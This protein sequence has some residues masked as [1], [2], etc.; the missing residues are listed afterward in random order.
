MGWQGRTGDAVKA[1]GMFLHPHQVT[2]F[3]SRFEEVS[4]WQAF[5]TRVEH[6]DFLEFNVVTSADEDEIADLT[7]K[8]VQAA[9]EAIKFQLQVKFVTEKDLPPN[10]SPIR[11]ERTWE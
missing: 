1:R 10:S 7:V 5:L 2:D 4:C 8:L 3:M 11:D 9:R 6:K